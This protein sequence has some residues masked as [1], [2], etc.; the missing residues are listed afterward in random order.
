MLGI[1]SRAVRERS[2]LLKQWRE[3]TKTSSAN[4]SAANSLQGCAWQKYKEHS[5]LNHLIP[6]QTKSTCCS[7][8]GCDI[9]NQ[10]WTSEALP[11]KSSQARRLKQQRFTLKRIF[12]KE[13][14][15][16]RSESFE[17][18]APHRCCQQNTDCGK[19][20]RTKK[21]KNKPTDK[22]QQK[23]YDCFQEVNCK[24][25]RNGEEHVC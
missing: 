1:D 9:R 6:Q 12:R 17:S 7:G 23:K 16:I 20:Y 18:P 19:L 15:I 14:Q 25:K 8:G 3:G 10:C 21:T 22:Q 24:E 13:G 5:S 4:C 2:I 11:S